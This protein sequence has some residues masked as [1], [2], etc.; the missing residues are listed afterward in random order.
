MYTC[1]LRVFIVGCPAS[2]QAVSGGA[3]RRRKV[4]GSIPDEVI[5]VIHSLG[6]AGALCPWGRLGL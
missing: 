1:N 2:L 4:A 3:V 5:G 6:P